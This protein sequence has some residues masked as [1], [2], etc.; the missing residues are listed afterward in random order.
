MVDLEVICANL[1]FAGFVFA[2]WY[3]G[4]R[5]PVFKK[6]AGDYLKSMIRMRTLQNKISRLEMALPVQSCPLKEEEDQGETIGVPLE[7]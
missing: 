4:V 5:Y 3:I 6:R 1:G 2:I 7:R